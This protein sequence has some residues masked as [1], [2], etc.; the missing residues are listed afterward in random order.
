MTARWSG[1]FRDAAAATPRFE[2][3]LEAERR[4]G[5]S[6][7]FGGQS[8]KKVFFAAGAREQTS[9]VETDSKHL[10][11]ASKEKPQ[12]PTRSTSPSD[13][14]AKGPDGAQRHSLRGRVQWLAKAER[15]E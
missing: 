13:R 5:F 9:V 3:D 1:V 4:R 15:S 7:A 10:G 12:G 14:K 2:E 11:G 6:T 8:P